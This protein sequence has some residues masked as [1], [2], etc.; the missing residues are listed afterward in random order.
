MNYMGKEEFECGRRRIMILG[1][2]YLEVQIG[3]EL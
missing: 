2:F 1:E 3:R